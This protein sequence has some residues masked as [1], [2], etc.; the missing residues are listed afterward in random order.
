MFEVCNSLLVR[1]IA[2]DSINYC[3]DMSMFSASLE[4]NWVKLLPTSLI[5][6]AYEKTALK[7][8]KLQKKGMTPVSISHFSS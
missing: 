2:L 3:S 8:K 5:E 7:H 6:A 4:K 1:N